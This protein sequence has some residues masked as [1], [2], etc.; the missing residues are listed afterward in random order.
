MHW[1]NNFYLFVFFLSR[2]MFSFSFEQM[3][4]QYMQRCEFLM[5]L[6]I[7]AV[8]AEF[9][10]NVTCVEC[11]MASTYATS[12]Q[13]P[14]RYRFYSTFVF[15]FKIRFCISTYNFEIITKKGN[16]CDLILTYLTLI[17]SDLCLFSH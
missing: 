9:S 16:I 12:T 10:L 1:N 7:A 4:L 3:V 17:D 11:N 15:V 8:C 2:K 5:C 14:M 13:T 6:I